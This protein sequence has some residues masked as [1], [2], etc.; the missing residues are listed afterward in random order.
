MCTGH[1]TFILIFGNVC[2]SSQLKTNLNDQEMNISRLYDL[3]L[4]KKYITIYKNRFN[5]NIYVKFTLLWNAL[6][7]IFGEKKISETFL[8]PQE[9]SSEWIDCIRLHSCVC[10]KKK[11]ILI[12]T[13]AYAW[14]WHE[15]CIS[16]TVFAMTNVAWCFKTSKIV[17]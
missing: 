3:V 16:Q 15:K 1:A 11:L 12:I 6:Y 17:S 5:D 4:L 13:Q 9:G 2:T 14:Y 8:M 7:L 10:K